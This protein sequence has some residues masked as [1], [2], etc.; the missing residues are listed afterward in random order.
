MT[1]TMA[2]ETALGTAAIAWSDAAIVGFAL[3]EPDPKAG[4]ARLT[5]RHGVPAGAAV[6][7]FVAE[8]ARR[9]VALIAGGFVTFDDIPLDFGAAPGF[10]RSVWDVARGIPPGET[11]TYGAVAR[12]LGDAGLARAVGAALGRNP[13]PL[14]VPCHRV[15][16]AGGRAGGF[17][18]E[19][20][21]ASKL[22]LLAIEDA[23]AARGLPLFAAPSGA[24]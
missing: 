3:P 15:T 5:M 21:V 16:A 20:G 19:G 12:Q 13:I 22:R 14:I 9:A 23:H 11:M 4:L 6:P 10:D 2:F 1:S 7:P 24:I 18:A 17:S 8:A